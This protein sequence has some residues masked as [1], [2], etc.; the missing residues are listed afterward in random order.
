M[1][2]FGWSFWYTLARHILEHDR[3]ICPVAHTAVQLELISLVSFTSSPSLPCCC[4]VRGVVGHR[5]GPG[6]IAEACWVLSNSKHF[7]VVV[8]SFVIWLV[9]LQ[10]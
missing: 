1:A 4:E 8:Q 10:H 7:T 2:S 3:P 5:A 6:C 9:A